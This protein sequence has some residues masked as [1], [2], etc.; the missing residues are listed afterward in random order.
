LLGNAFGTIYDFSTI[1]ILWFAGASAMAGLLNLIPRYL[2]RF[3][4]APR[5]VSYRRPLVLVLLGINIVITLIFQ[6][7]VEAQG[8]AYATGVLVLMLSAAVAVSIALWK[9]CS[10]QSP[11]TVLRAM[12]FVVVTLVFVYTLVDNILERPDGILIAIAFI[13]LLLLASAISRS[14]RSLELR[15]TDLTFA[16]TESAELWDTIVGKKVNLVPYYPEDSFTRQQVEQKLHQHYVIN[17][18]V[19]FLHVSLLDNRSE[20]TANL[21]LRVTRDG[22]NYLLE[23]SGAV[24][25]ANSV[26]YICELLDPV[27]VILTLTTRNLMKQSIAYL[28][29]GEGETALVAYSILVRRWEWTGKKADRPRVFLMSG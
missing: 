19:A 5:W 1:F 4:M 17:E 25:V 3:G 10:I 15:I 29:F 16:D 12:Y 27:S 13:V 26:A 9:E 28:L 24:A 21:R 14:V 23:V 2:P 18:P 8:G 7:S 6:A 11:L 20:F 22:E